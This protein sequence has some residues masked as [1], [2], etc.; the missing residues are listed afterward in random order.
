MITVTLDTNK[1]QA[2]LQQLQQAMGDLQPV[3][4]DIGATLQSLILRNL[5][6]GM[7][8]WGEPMQPLKYRKG[9]PL[10]NTRQHIYNRITHQAMPEEVQIGLFDADSNKI[11]RVHQFGASITRAAH[12]REVHFKVNT[13]TGQSRFAKRGKANLTQDVQ[14]PETT[15]K[16]PARPFMPIRPDLSVDLPQAWAD[17]VMGILARNIRKAMD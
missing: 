17:K 6:Q 14:M 5:G 9:V 7:T 16:I 2:A 15:F 12:T 11:G 8:P 1:V 3:M 13:R 4:E 10:N